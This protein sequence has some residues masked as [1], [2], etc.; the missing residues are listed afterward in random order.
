MC[1]PTEALLLVAAAASVL[2]LAIA[3]H[4]SDLVPVSVLASLVITKL[5]DAE[6]DDE[7]SSFLASLEEEN[8]VPLILEFLVVIPLMLGL[9]VVIPLVSTKAEAPTELALL[10]SA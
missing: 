4:F 9:L 5:E 1:A 3:C 6:E 7:V 10:W 2:A 8:G